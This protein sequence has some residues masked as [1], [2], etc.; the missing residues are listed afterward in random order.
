MILILKTV[1]DI[2]LGVVTVW[3]VS[4][5]LELQRMMLTLKRSVW[6]LQ[7]REY[8]KKHKKV[9]R[10]IKKYIVVKGKVTK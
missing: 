1:L 2:A 7:E 10:D 6:E 3:C 8:L 9:H 4:K 5:I